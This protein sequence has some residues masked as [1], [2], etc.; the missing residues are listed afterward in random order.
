MKIE[1]PEIADESGTEYWSNLLSIYRTSRRKQEKEKLKE[2][3][4]KAMKGE[5]PSRG[6]KSTVK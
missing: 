1:T 6:G 4:T 3:N 2:E 5:D